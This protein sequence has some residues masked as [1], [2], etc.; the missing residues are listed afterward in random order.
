[1]NNEKTSEPRGKEMIQ[2]RENGRRQDSVSKALSEGASSWLREHLGI[3]EERIITEANDLAKTAGRNEI[4]P[5]DKGLSMA[6][7]G[8]RWGGPIEPGQVKCVLRYSFEMRVS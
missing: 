7:Q 5:A 4:E 2:E 1:M 6:P 3:I 8:L